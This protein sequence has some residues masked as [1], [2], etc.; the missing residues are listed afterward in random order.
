ME[1]HM[2]RFFVLILS[3]A[4]LTACGSTQFEAPP[5]LPSNQP[6][7]NGSGVTPLPATSYLPQETDAALT[8]NSVTLESMEI[9]TLES[10]PLQF[11]LALKGTLPTICHQL[12]VNI[13]EPNSK[14]E[15]NVE[16]YSVTDPNEVCALVVTPFEANIGLNSFP[17]GTYNILVNGESAGQISIASAD[18]PPHSMKGYELYSWQSDGLWYFSLLTGTNRMK[19]ID[20]ITDPTVRLDGAEALKTELKKLAAGEFVTWSMIQGYPNLSLPPEDI[21]ND[22]RAYSEQLGLQF[23]IV[24]P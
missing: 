11:T 13:N 10:F 15:I 8:R 7:D 9:L 23:D 21:V 22:I 18:E 12:R 4:L 14:N 3:A 1:Y 17:V 16:V 24:M 2:T 19:T 6:V 20:E 5:S